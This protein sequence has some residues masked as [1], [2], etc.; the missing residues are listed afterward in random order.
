MGV[1]ASQ[2]T[3]EGFWKAGRF[4]GSVIVLPLLES[5]TST[6]IQSLHRGAYE[7]GLRFSFGAANA[8]HGSSDT[9]GRCT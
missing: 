8:E 6:V 1:R 3:T 2:M 7:I 4:P 9:V 5:S